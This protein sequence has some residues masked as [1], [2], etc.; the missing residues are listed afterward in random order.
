MVD[1]QILDEKAKKLFLDAYSVFDAT[2]KSETCCDNCG[3]I[4]LFVRVARTAIKH[5]CPCGK[6]SGEL[7]GL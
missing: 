7:K 2:G 6:Y 5:S 1:H 3:G 4:I